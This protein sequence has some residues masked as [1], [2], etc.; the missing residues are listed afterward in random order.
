MTLTRSDVRDVR[1]GD[2]HDTRELLLN[3]ARQAKERNYSD[4][5]IVDVDAHHYE[6]ESMFEI[7]Q[8][9]EDPVI[10]H[11]AEAG[12]VGKLIN[13][14]LLPTQPGNQDLAG[15][16]T[17]Y[18]LRGLERP[19]GEGHRDVALTK[20]YMEMMGIDYTILFPTPMLNLGLH[21]Q[22][23]MEV[24]VARA[25]ARWITE[26]ILPAD[27]SI[28][29]MLYLPFNDPEASLKIVE[30]F[31]DKPGV[32]GFMITSV[33]YRPIHH[34]V[35]MKLYAA[36]EDSGMPLG[37]HAGYN[38]QERAMEQLNK[39]I[40]VHALG[41]PFYNM[42]HLT[43]WVIN[44]MPERFS[45][46][47]VI[48][49]EGGLAWVTFLMQRLDNEYLMRSSEAPLLK[50]LPSEYMQ[51]FFYTT[52]PMEIPKD[53]DIL[54]MTFKMI[55]AESQLLYSSDYPH[56]DFDA[57]STIYD[58]PFLDERSKRNILGE[59]ARRLF[60]LDIG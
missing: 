19:E 32:V 1:V 36:I 30:E 29:T 39:F 4:F 25:Y 8:Y 34:N 46:L 13:Q 14:S 40:S 59:N 17:R 7:I 15:R 33:R 10:R 3:A 45:N 22:V 56:W 26:K 44:G 21:P 23:E 5:L 31:S 41:F 50:R 51:E 9:I 38:W 27:P 47:K 18:R 57:P 11:Y 52:Q 48:W 16:V 53:P 12:G 60:N 35:Y 49:I 55:N 2:R 43:N 58:L 54:K 24:A 37:I 28:K 42:I 6:S 20:R